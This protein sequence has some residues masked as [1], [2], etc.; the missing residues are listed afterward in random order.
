EYQPGSERATQGHYR[1][2]A[3]KVISIMHD[4][5]SLCVW[6]CCLLINILILSS[7]MG[8]GNGA[9]QGTDT[10]TRKKHHH[11]NGKGKYGFLVTKKERNYLHN[12]FEPLLYSN[13]NKVNGFPYIAK[14]SKSFNVENSKDNQRKTI[15]HSLNS[16]IENKPLNFKDKDS[17]KK[18]KREFKS[19][20]RKNVNTDF[21]NNKRN[22]NYRK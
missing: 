9:V 20:E 3:V 19:F 14:S 17:P 11:N 8:I 21:I 16:L 22:G 2:F 5:S 1:E 13:K 6:T 7:N 10:F 15:K 12:T 18:I 4:V